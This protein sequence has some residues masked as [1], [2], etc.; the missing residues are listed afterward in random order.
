MMAEKRC[1]LRGREPPN[2]VSNQ[3]LASSVNAIALQSEFKGEK[4][5][6]KEYL[7]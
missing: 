4:G 5:C 6:L 2:G 1:K 3:Y 7:T